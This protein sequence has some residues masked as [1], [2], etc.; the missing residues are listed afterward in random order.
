MSAHRGMT[1]ATRGLVVAIV[2]AAEPFIVPACPD[3]GGHVH[4]AG[5][6][7]GAR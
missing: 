6:C 1:L 5:P 2:A 4:S 3:C 7:G